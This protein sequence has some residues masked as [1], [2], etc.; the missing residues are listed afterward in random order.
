[1]AL[2]TTFCTSADSG[3]DFVWPDSMVGVSSKMPNSART[4]SKDRIMIG[5][6]PRG[7]GPGDRIS[8]NG[9]FL[10][11]TLQRSKC[12]RE[13]VSKNIARYKKTQVVQ[14][15][16]ANEIPQS[17]WRGRLPCEAQNFSL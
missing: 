1:M 4:D 17:F 2:L 15:G 6:L 16:L 13:Q 8:T 11:I 7:S 9:E 12:A 14:S 10:P 5:L 3:A